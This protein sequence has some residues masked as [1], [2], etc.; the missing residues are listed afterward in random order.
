MIF[1]ADI[2][3]SSAF[4][5][6]KRNENAFMDIL[7]KAS[8]GLGS[9]AFAVC[10]LFLDLMGGIAIYSNNYKSAGLCLI[11]SVVMLLAALV[12]AFFRK[13][14]FNILSVCFNIA[15]TLLYIY[16]IAVLN[17]IPNSVVPR[18]SIE[19]ITSRIYP[20]IIVTIL[21]LTAV[22]A[23]FFSYDRMVQREKKKS[24]RDK[25]RHRSLT[26]DEKII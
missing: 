11:I 10:C 8:L 15:G 14:L 1:I 18:S 25:E 2:F 7:R 22:F 17:G 3:V 23:D 20:T 21:L 4:R 26:D 16:P 5:K 19:I 13:G 24:E 6:F 9:A 12:A